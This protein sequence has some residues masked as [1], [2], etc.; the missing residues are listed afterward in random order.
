MRGNRREING[1]G[2]EGRDRRGEGVAM[3]GNRGGVI[4]RGGTRGRGGGGGGLERRNGEPGAVERDGARMGVRGRGH[5]VDRRWGDRRDGARDRQATDSRRS[6]P[7]GRAGP[8]LGFKALEDLAKE[9]PAIVAIRLSTHPALPGLLGEAQMKH[10]LVELLCLAISKAFQSRAERST[11]QHLASIIKESL[12]FR[13]ALLYYIRNM[14]S[15][16]SPVRRARYP[17]QLQN[18]LAILSK[19]NGDETRSVMTS[20]FT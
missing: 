17:Q 15:D 4:Q 5:S 13:A 10:D 3:R 6:S 2:G 19:V 8:R 18:I 1:R 16:S 9:D 12:F 7:A 20:V 11:L 14:Q